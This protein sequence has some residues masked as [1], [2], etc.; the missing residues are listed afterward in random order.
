[1]NQNPEPGDQVF[2]NS[3]T[4]MQ[5]KMTVAQVF[6]GIHVEAPAELV[7]FAKCH[8]FDTDSQ[9]Q[10]VILAVTELTDVPSSP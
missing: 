3:D 5:V 6:K 7:A 9:F 4:A 1:M 8:Y 2:L 10:E